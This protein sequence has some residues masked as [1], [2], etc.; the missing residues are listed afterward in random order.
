MSMKTLSR[1]KQC[2][3]L[4]AAS[5]VAIVATLAA[6]PARADD[7]IDVQIDQAKIIQLPD[8][9]A[10]VVIGNPI[11]A[12]V[13]LLKG[14]GKMVLTGKGFGETNL[15]ALDASGNSLGESTIRVKAGFRGL[16]VQRGSDRESYSCLPRCQPSVV[17]GDSPKFVGDAAGQI[18]AHT[19][20]SAGGK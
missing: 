15:I 12:D 20:M 18:Q 1:R 6:A 13:T 3:H 2:A 5:L 4:T 7:V 11:V 14:G 10:T 19:A 9:T 17:L 8:R 16:V